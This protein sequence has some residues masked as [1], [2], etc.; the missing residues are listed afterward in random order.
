[1]QRQG[2]TERRKR[3]S[4]GACV[5]GRWGGLK[6]TGY[7]EGE[8]NLNFELGLEG[9]R[10]GVEKI[11]GSGRAKTRP[12]VRGETGL[13]D[14]CGPGCQPV[15]RAAFGGGLWHQWECKSNAVGPWK[16]APGKGLEGS[17]WHE[18]DGFNQVYGVYATQL[19]AVA[20]GGAR[21]RTV[22]LSWCQLYCHSQLQKGPS[23]KLCTTL[24]QPSSCP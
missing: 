9:M 2:N 10:R 17:R 1:M 11:L 20:H 24:S 12:P 8:R 23:T 3:R 7:D 21:C 16:G 15:G 14:H 4:R 13:E 18:Q 19:R 6:V 5:S 22:A